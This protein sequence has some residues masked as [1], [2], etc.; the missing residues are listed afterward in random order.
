MGKDD[1]RMALRINGQVYAKIHKLS[2]EGHRS[3]NSQ[4]NMLLTAGLDAIEE[5]AGAV[6]DL[7]IVK[8]GN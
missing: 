7:G 5:P 4:V 3:M 2:L 8:P 6:R 1:R